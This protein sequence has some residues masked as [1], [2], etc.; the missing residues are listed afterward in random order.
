MLRIYYCRRIALY[1]LIS[2]DKF[3]YLCLLPNPRHFEDLW[4]DMLVLFLYFLWL[5]CT[6][7]YLGYV[8]EQ[9]LFPVF[10]GDS[11]VST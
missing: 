7:V 3:A 4:S 1:L 10:F 2:V 8:D 11:Q 9:M 5:C 6:A